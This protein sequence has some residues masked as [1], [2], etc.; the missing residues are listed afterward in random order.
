M[1]ISRKLR[2]DL[3]LIGGLNSDNDSVYLDKNN[4][5][6]TSKRWCFTNY[7]Y[8]IIHTLT[9]SKVARNGSLDKVTD[10][11]LLEINQIFSNSI[12]NDEKE[13]LNKA[14]SNLTMI[15]QKND[16]SKKEYLDQTLEKILKLPIVENLKNGGSEF[17][18]VIEEEDLINPSKKKELN[19]DFDKAQENKRHI[20]SYVGFP[21]HFML[22]RPPSLAD[23][24]GFPNVGNTCYLNSV[25]QCFKAFSFLEKLFSLSDNP[26]L[27]LS[28]QEDAVCIKIRLQIS[29]IFKASFKNNPIKPEMMIEL[30]GLFNKLNPEIVINTMEDPKVIIEV[31]AKIFNWA[32][33]FETYD[34]L[35]EDVYDPYVISSLVINVQHITFAEDFDKKKVPITQFPSSLFVRFQVQGIPSDTTY[36]FRHES[37]MAPEN[38]NL[39]NEISAT[40]VPYKLVGLIVHPSG[41]Y[42]SYLRDGDKW[43]CFDDSKV[44]SMDTLPDHAKT[45]ILF[46]FYE[47]DDE[48]LI[49]WART[50]DDS[51]GH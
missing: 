22:T 1:K 9:F 42:V 20:L 15:I 12:T 41:H 32:I 16:G 26:L 11:I 49:S 7:I 43:V 28:E 25:L 18:E 3:E 10:H 17:E 35:E 44:T 33:C 34:D 6:K 51:P 36:N 48:K 39:G 4:V 50:A 2:N 38:I 13:L 29:E 5:T 46:A 40:R 19:P 8:R 37:F 47:R 21:E 23:T 31:L 14:I 45:Q 24:T 30:Q 27:S